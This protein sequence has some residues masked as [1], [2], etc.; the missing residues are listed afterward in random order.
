[1]DQGYACV[2]RSLR[3]N[4]YHYPDKLALVEA[5]GLK[6]TYRQMNDHVNR[7]AQLFLF[8]GLG[9]GDHVAILSWNSFEHILALYAT[10]KIGGV[11][12]ALDP[13]WTA[14]EVARTLAFFD[15]KL[16]VLD[17]SLREKLAETD[18]RHLEHGVIGYSK[19]DAWSSDLLDLIASMTSAEPDI[20]VFDHDVF[21]MILTSG[22]TGLPKGCIRTHRNV[23]IGCIKDI[24]GRSMHDKSQELVVAPI[25]YGTARG[26]VLGQIYLGGTVHIMSSFDAERVA[27]YID[28]ER[29]TAIALAPTMCSRLLK[30]PNLD[31]Y[32]FSSI[33][34]LRKAGSPFTLAMVTELR[35]RITKNIYQGFAATESG[36]VT[37]LKPHEQ[38]SKLGS[39]GLPRW[40]VEMELVDSDRK[41]VPRGEEGEIR[42]RSANVCRGYYKNPE[43]QNKVFADGWYYTGDL[44]RLD[45]EG[46]LYVVGRIKDIIKTGSINV[47]PREIENTIL[48]LTGVEDVAVVGV[49]DPEW[50]EAVKAVVVLKDGAAFTANDIARHCRKSLAGF[51]S[52][53]HIQFVDHIE[54]NQLGKVT[55]EFKAAVTA[56]H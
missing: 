23:E 49:P 3:V 6:L 28:R 8:K 56:N 22:T 32:D 13:R 36:G 45:D 47:S 21:T 15:C 16:L 30:L 25:Y 14:T 29:I 11:S 43:E 5:D 31:K 33:Q 51:K 37:M 7:L 44:G 4:A 41:L 39:S 50:G 34:S 9:R 26:S 18:F 40:G 55:A 1:M 42:V 19:A 24:M 54:R 38:I 35:E 20:K 2:G 48:A 53:K 46:Y 17:E 10:A 27:A 12:I 52:P